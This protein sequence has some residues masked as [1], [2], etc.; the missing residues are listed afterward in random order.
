[1]RLRSGKLQSKHSHQMF[2][3][4][5]WGSAIR[6]RRWTKWDT[7]VRQC[8][9][10]TLSRLCPH[11]LADLLLQSSSGSV[12]TTGR[13]TRSFTCWT[14][15]NSVCCIPVLNTL[16][17]NSSKTGTQSWVIGYA[18]TRRRGWWIWSLLNEFS[19]C[20]ELSFLSCQRILVLLEPSFS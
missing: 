11:V 13:T 7:A 4:S 19:V 5:C 16:G 14:Q 20:V 3:I 18:R 17:T 9:W 8:C 15:F 2:A 6:S 1:M 10:S 12:P